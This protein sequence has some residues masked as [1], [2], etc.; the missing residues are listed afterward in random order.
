MGKW[1]QISLRETIEWLGSLGFTCFWQG[2]PGGDACAVSAIPQL[3]AAYFNRTWGRRLAP[4]V[5]PPDWLVDDCMQR[6]SSVKVQRLAPFV[7]H[8]NYDL[9]VWSNVVCDAEPALVAMLRR[10][11]LIT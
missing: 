9:R 2:N 1:R 3:T 8:C 11:V 6:P 7:A 4:W 10:F 5:P